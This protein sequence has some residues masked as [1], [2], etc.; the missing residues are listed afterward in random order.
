[1]YKDAITL[2]SVQTCKELRRCLSG[3]Y[4]NQISK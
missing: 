1:M 2:F 4:N 3:S